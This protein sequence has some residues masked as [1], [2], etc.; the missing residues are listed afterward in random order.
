MGQVSARL[1]HERRLRRE[2]RERSTALRR[3]LTPSQRHELEVIFQRAD[4]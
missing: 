2:R 1:Q 4:R 3:A